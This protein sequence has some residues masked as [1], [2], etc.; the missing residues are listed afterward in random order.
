VDVARYGKDETVIAKKTGN[1]ITFEEIF[2]KKDLMETAGRVIQILAGNKGA[3]V[4]IDSIGVGGG[5]ADRLKEQ[6]FNMV[7]VVS[8]HSAIQNNIYKNKRAENYFRLRDLLPELDIPN[9]EKL[10]GQMLSIRY[11]TF[12]DGLLIIES[13]DELS[14]RGL[15]SPDRL[16]AIVIACSEEQ[17]TEEG[18]VYTSVSPPVSIEDEAEIDEA[19]RERVI[20]MIDRR[21]FASVAILMHATGYSEGPLGEMLVKMNFVEHRPGHFIFGKGFK[22]ELPKKKD[23][24]IEDVDVGTVGYL[25]GLGELN[26]G[27]IKTRTNIE[28]VRD[29]AALLVRRWN[30]VDIRKLEAI[31]KLGIPVIEDCLRKLN[32]RK[33]FMEGIWKKRRKGILK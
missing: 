10:R 2:S 32:Y 17:I 3:P 22:R 20:N 19:L 24:E 6:N 25:S 23:E 1:K 28:I 8:S 21:G 31:T 4:K 27:K 30:E 29:H 16:D 9:D 11:R 7:E 5:V 13:K 18:T 33:T 15:S 26:A 14:R 12:S